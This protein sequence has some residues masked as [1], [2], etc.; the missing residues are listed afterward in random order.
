M[1]SLASY[2]V[3]SKVKSMTGD[4]GKTFGLGDDEEDKKKE[5]E[6]S[7]AEKAVC[8]AARGPVC[9]CGRGR[10]TDTDSALRCA[11]PAEK[12]GG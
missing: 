2:L 12:E 4:L 7:P 9:L 1:D 10:R 11:L 6:D 5:E 3:Q 8:A